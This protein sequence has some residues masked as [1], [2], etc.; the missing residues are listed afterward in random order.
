[1]SYRGEIAICP[2]CG[3]EF[4][5]S[6]PLQVYCDPVCQLKS[7]KLRKREYSKR[8]YA[9]NRE[10]V[11]SSRRAYYLLKGKKAEREKRYELDELAVRAVAALTDEQR[12]KLYGIF[13][14]NREWNEEM[15]KWRDE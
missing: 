7:S 4:A 12:E 2:M 1:M 8:Y 10:K 14:G 11:Q 6:H 9:A 3:K 15:K 5:K 13:A